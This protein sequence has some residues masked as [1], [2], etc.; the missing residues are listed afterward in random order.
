MPAKPIRISGHARFEMRRR[1]ITRR[2]VVHMVRRPGQVVPSMK[3]RHIYQG[4]VGRLGRAGRLLL[5]VIVTEGAR[6]Y[7][8]VTAYKTS[9]IAKYWRTP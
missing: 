8:V 5:R 1:G 2:E 3:G 9:K 6:A 7:H 4:R